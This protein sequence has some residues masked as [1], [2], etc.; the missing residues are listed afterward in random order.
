MTMKI[1]CMS[2]MTMAEIIFNKYPCVSYHFS[3]SLAVEFEL[4]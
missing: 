2:E 1:E 3:L 4:C